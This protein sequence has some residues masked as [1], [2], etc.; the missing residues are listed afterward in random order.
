MFVSFTWLDPYCKA[1]QH[2]YKLVNITYTQMT[3]KTKVVFI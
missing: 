2:K 1:K 3:K